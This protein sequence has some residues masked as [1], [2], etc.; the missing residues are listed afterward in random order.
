MYPFFSKVAFTHRMYNNQLQEELLPFGISVTQWALIRYLK[1]NGSATF[2]DVA[3]YWQVEK[4][5][6]TPIA[7]KLAAREIILISSG[8]D[9]RQKIMYL[10]EKGEALHKTIMEATDPF[11][12]E[13]LE[14]ISP[15]E[16]DAAATILEKIIMNL[17]RRG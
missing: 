8:S 5:A 2:S 14:G 10:S 7:Q 12:E 4:P 6:I 1:N 9:K 3:D 15:E 13:I 11:L 17:K 16:R